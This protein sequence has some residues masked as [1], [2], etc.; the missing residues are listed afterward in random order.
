MTGEYVERI[1]V[2]MLFQLTASLAPGT[3]VAISSW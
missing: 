3:V 2:M 1:P